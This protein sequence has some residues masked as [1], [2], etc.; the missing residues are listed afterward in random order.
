MKR[1]NYSTTT[2]PASHTQFSLNANA[3]GTREY[4][5]WLWC[6]CKICWSPCILTDFSNTFFFFNQ[7]YITYRLISNSTADNYSCQTDTSYQNVNHMNNGCWKV[8]IHVSFSWYYF[9]HIT[10]LKNL[11]NGPKIKVFHLIC[12]WATW[13]W[14]KRQIAINVDKLS[15]LIWFLADYLNKTDKG[16]MSRLLTK[17]TDRHIF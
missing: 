9:N 12:S 1:F 13:V 16:W 8:F 11:L 14:W 5:R 7:L 6:K 15:F 4:P 17:P 2:L 3:T 10:I